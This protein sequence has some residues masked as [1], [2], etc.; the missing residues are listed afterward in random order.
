MLINPF[1]DAK[2]RTKEK[3]RT[4]LLGRLSVGGHP[5]HGLNHILGLVGSAEH[6]PMGRNYTA[7]LGLQGIAFFKTV[8]SYMEEPQDVS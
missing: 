3:R 6:R 7:L 2:T 1:T 8:E 4:R 5:G